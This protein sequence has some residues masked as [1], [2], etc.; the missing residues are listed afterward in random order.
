MSR[1]N[2]QRPTLATV[3]AILFLLSHLVMTSL[4]LATSKK[5]G[6][7]MPSETIQ[8]E[9]AI[10]YSDSPMEKTYDRL[11]E[12]LMKIMTQNEGDEEMTQY[13][14]AIAGGPGS[15]K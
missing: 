2:N 3:T 10:L 1:G 15:G 12:R 7:T 14:V 11:A 4:A 9:S 6:G 8:K 5:N 13:W